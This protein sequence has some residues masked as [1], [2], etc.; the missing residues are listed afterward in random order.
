GTTT[1][2]VTHDQAEAMT[3]AQRVAVL[4]DGVLQ[5]VDDPMTIYHRPANQFVA[6][7]VGS[8]AMN[9]VEGEIDSSTG[10]FVCAE[11][12]VR[13]P[14]PLR[15]AAQ[16]CVKV[17]LGVRPE[18]IALSRQSQP[19]WHSGR[20]FVC[21]RTGNETLVSFQCGKQRLTARAPGNEIYDFDQA[22]WFS[23]DT[24]QLHLFETRTGRALRSAGTSYT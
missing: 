19:G 9:F 11:L 13:L 12:R 1:L 23:F 18:H 2:Y 6:G 21:E 8:P 20:I 10:Y 4:R 14:E 22:V 15:K 24:S 3:L 7:F 5:Q 16:G 17:T